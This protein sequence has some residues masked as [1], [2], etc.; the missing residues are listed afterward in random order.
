MG[1][2]AAGKPPR[3]P[4]KVTIVPEGGDG[5]PTEV[6]TALDAPDDHE[7][8]PTEGYRVPTPIAAETTNATGWNSANRPVTL[9]PAARF[10]LRA[11]RMRKVWRALETVV[12]G[13]L[14]LA[15]APIGG[16]LAVNAW[17]HRNDLT[18]TELREASPLLA[19]AAAALWMVVLL[20]W[21]LWREGRIK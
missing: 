10:V 16:Y 17:Q 1:V 2:H 8:R 6:Y 9:G 20:L 4:R 18:L 13:C 7:A 14:A 19:L 21:V 12:F 11:Q 3:P 15:L 5:P